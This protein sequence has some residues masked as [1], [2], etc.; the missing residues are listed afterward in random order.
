MRKNAASTLLFIHMQLFEKAQLVW[1][2]INH[3]CLK[4]ILK[5]LP[6]VYV[7]KPPDHLTTFLP[8][9]NFHLNVFI[10]STSLLTF[11]LEDFT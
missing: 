6:S 8:E 7:F 3:A 1:K 11:Q 5:Y 4:F 10:F 9:A 2:K